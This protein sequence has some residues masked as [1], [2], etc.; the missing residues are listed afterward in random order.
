MEIDYDS[1]RVHTVY[2]TFDG[3]TDDGRSFT[4][5]CNWNDVDDWAVDD[6]RFDNG[7]NITE[8]EFEEI[9]QE[10]LSQMN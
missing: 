1:K 3:E 6:I 7:D 2:A 9:K 10:F 4:I 5:E 8:E